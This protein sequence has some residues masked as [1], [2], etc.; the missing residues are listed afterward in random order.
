[1]SS[2]TPGEVA[3][4]GAPLPAISSRSDRRPRRMKRP[5]STSM[6]SA[7]CTG[8]GRCA[9]HCRS[10]LPALAMRAGQRRPRRLARA[11]CAGARSGGLGGTERFR[12]HLAAERSSRLQRQF[13][14]QRR[15]RG[16]DCAASGGTTPD[17][18]QRARVHRRGHQQRACAASATRARC[19]REE[20][21]RLVHR[22]AAEQ[23]QQYR[24]LHAVHV[25]RLALWPRPAPAR[26]PQVANAARVL[27]VL[28]AKA[29]R[30]S[31]WP[32]A[33]RCCRRS[34]HDAASVIRGDDIRYRS[35]PPAQT[36]SP[37][38]P[39][40]RR[41]AV[42]R[43]PALRLA[44]TSG[45]RD[46]SSVVL[47]GATQRGAESGDEAVPVPHRF[48]THLPSPGRGQRPRFAEG[49]A[50]SNVASARPGTPALLRR[51][52][53]DR[54]GPASATGDGNAADIDEPAA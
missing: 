15:G 7:S 50:R 9:A 20:R 24:K 1:M 47:V 22:G 13:G 46:G 49:I 44:T 16:D 36:R 12:A 43:M 21:S 28:V 26:Q 51:A 38:R 45:A 3:E 40:H 54:H 25:L 27:R 35:P 31:G 41:A 11:W 29:P 4:R 10:R 52:D 32:A 48:T 14:R 17:A 23:R 39:R 37:P 18:Q 53:G 5:A 6:R 33:R 42:R 2:S 30:S 19:R 8:A 34:K